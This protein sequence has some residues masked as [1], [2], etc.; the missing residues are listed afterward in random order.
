MKPRTLDELCG[1]PPGTFNSFI[2]GQKKELAD[3]E[4]ARKE[5][6]RAARFDKKRL[7]V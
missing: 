4:K 2:E 3:E 5:R 7:I 1:Q 6:I